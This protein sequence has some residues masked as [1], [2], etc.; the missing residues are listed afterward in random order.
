MPLE[1]REIHIKATISQEEGND[2][3]SSS[4]NQAIDI[5]KIIAECVRRVLQILRLK[6]DR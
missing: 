3:S 6:S 2:S 4:E 5:E 1:I